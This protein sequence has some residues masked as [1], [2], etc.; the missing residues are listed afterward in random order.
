MRHILSQDVVFRVVADEAVVLKVQDG[1]VIGLNGT[2][3]EVLSMV[4]G[5][6]SH[7]EIVAAFGVKHGLDPAK[8]ESDVLAFL[9]ELVRAGV[10]IRSGT[11]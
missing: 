11:P 7:A 5:G 8:A 1:E 6:R 9:D 4:S 10:L 2:G 3:A